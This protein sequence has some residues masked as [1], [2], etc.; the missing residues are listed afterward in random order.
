MSWEG[1]EGNGPCFRIGHIILS[2]GCLETSYIG[3]IANRFGYNFRH[4]VWIHRIKGIL[5]YYPVNQYNQEHLDK[6]NL[7]LQYKLLYTA[8]AIKWTILNNYF[9]SVIVY[10]FT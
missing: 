2:A 9:E 7:N 6:H 5:E 4:N 1:E 10:K 8:Y 3:L